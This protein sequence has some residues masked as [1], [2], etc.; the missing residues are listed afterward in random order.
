MFIIFESNKTTAENKEIITFS[1]GVLNKL[2]YLF[3]FD[4]FSKFPFD[5]LRGDVV[6][7]KMYSIR[8]K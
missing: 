6:H 3:T 2:K 8:R 1:I 4:D 5:S 7:Y